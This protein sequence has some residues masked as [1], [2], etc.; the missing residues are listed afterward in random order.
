[1]GAARILK[2]GGVR[3]PVYIAARRD[4]MAHFAKYSKPPKGRAHGKER[5]SECHISTTDLHERTR[6]GTWEVGGDRVRSSPLIAK[7]ILDQIL[8]EKKKIIW[9]KILILTSR[10][11]SLLRVPSLSPW[12]PWPRSRCSPRYYSDPLRNFT[13]KRWVFSSFGTPCLEQ[14]E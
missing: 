8:N 2:P 6:G 13:P 5:R 7:S 10:I 3:D 12:P 4:I 14:F 1:M 9:S 11:F